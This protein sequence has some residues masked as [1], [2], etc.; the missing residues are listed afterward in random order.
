M[1][2]TLP[3]TVDGVASSATRAPGSPL[4]LGGRLRRQP[5]TLAALAFL[6]IIAAV[7]FGS[8]VVLGS[9]PGL[10]DLDNRLAG[11]SLGHLLGTDELGRDQLHRLLL[12][13]HLSLLAAM[14]ATGIAFALGV[15]LGLSA[16]YL[17]GAF[18]ALL[19]R[20]A[21]AL[22]SVP[23]L[24]LALAIVGI[25]GPGLGNAMLA[26][27]LTYAPRVFRIARSAALTARQ[28]T[29][30]EAARAVGVTRGAIVLGHVLPN[31]V[32][33]L[34]VQASLTFG[35]TLLAEAS[36]SFLGL[37]VQPPDASWGTLLGRAARSMDENPILV[38]GPGLAIVV[39]VLAFNV[40]GDGLRRAVL[41]EEN[42]P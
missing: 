29:F 16:G 1:S 37:G 28:E 20:C 41:R 38:V 32:S 4:T 25:R 14:E 42:A 36:L 8:P 10:G 33:P 6:V 21:D 26:I 22:L 2:A 27:G 9:D 12:A 19:S 40:L 18:D 3:S 24:I 35:F 11:P 30:V 23:P 39:T 15:P 5:G 34:L 13:G 31:V 17:G 7:S